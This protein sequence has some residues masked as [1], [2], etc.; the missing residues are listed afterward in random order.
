MAKISFDGLSP[1]QAGRLRDALAKPYRGPAG[2]QTLGDQI[3]TLSGEK[4]ITDGMA[5]YSRTRFNRMSDRDQEAY[6]KRLEAKRVYLLA[7]AHPEYGTVWFQVPKIVFDA[8]ESEPDSETLAPGETWASD[9]QLAELFG[10][11]NP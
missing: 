6:I 7:E 9:A 1:M 4:R 8:V 10:T 3:A 2:I 11:A 5:D